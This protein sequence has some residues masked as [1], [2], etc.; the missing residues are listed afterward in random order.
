MTASDTEPGVSGVEA[1]V[2]GVRGGVDD[3][4]L[5]TV[6]ARTDALEGLRRF[7]DAE[8]DALVGALHIDL[9]LSAVESH[10]CEIGPV[11]AQVEHAL[12]RIGVWTRPERHGLPIAL[13][14]GSARTE[15][16]PKGVALILAPATS[17]VQQLLAPLTAA[18]AAGNGALLGASS[19]CGAT[20]DLIASRFD[21]YLDAAV[22]RTVP[23]DPAVGTALLEREVDHV[24]VS[25]GAETVRA[26]RVRA[27]EHGTS[28]TTTAGAKSPAIVAASA[29]ISAAARR[30]AH[31]KFAKAGQSCLAPD[32]AL[33]PRTSHSEFV[34]SVIDA[35][36]E[37]Y[38]AAPH[39]SPDFARIVSP[40]RVDRLTDLVRAGGY[41]A[42]AAGGGADR[43]SRYVDPTVLAGVS[44]D[45]A[46]MS[47]E[48]CGPILPVLAYE[49]LADAIEFV[50]RRARPLVVYPF[51][52]RTDTDLIVA[53]VAAEAVVVDHVFQPTPVPGA[54]SGGLGADRGEAGFRAMSRFV[55]VV[56]RRV[57]ADSALIAPPHSDATGR[58]VR[59]IY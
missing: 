4:R 28:C 15:V 33:V 55:P 30:I 24:V 25:G 17:P 31:G 13:R 35:I 48:I 54:S 6:S 14:P 40:A 39:E 2:A 46:V 36:R 9:G 22:V 34:A 59:R 49:S 12:E 37:M 53:A 16:K 23:T 58:R 3:G 52:R 27:A 11:V 43:D 42:V 8:Y 47:E 45:A 19:A 57:L 44:H 18:L 32:Y 1:A 21:R 26:V 38:G 20:T 10:L 51:G 50:N 7:L 5:R 41:Q 56:R 29:D